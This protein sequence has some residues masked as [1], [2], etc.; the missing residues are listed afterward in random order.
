MRRERKDSG[1]LHGHNNINNNNNNK[2]NNTPF[3]AAIITKFFQLFE[4]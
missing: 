2:N 3:M 1:E 4:N